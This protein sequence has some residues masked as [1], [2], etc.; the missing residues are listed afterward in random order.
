MPDVHRVKK[1]EKSW[2]ENT[3]N[4]KKLITRQQISEKSTNFQTNKQTTVGSFASLHNIFSLTKMREKNSLKNNDR[5]ASWLMLNFI[6][7]HFLDGLL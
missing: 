3:N 5:H 4:T 6:K 2:H 1:N 7:N